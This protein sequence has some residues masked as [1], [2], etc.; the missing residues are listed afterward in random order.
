MCLRAQMEHRS[1]AYKHSQVRRQESAALTPKPNAFRTGIWDGFGTGFDS[2]KY[3]SNG[4]R[5]PDLLTRKFI[6]TT[7]FEALRYI[8]HF[9]D[10]IAFIS[11]LLF[12]LIFM[13]LSGITEDN[14]QSNQITNPPFWHHDIPG[15]SLSF[16]LHIYIYICT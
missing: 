4:V 1:A 16:F 11:M 12:P 15:T 14:T 9:N 6:V 8:P 10:G 5:S 3:I 2:T 7:M 13:Y